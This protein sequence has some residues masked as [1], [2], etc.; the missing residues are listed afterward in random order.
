MVPKQAEMD[1]VV[2]QI[3]KAIEH[4]PHLQNTLFVLAGDHGMTQTG[5]HG[6]DTPSEIASAMV[7]IS[8]RFRSIS[9]GNEST[10]EA[11]EDFEYYSV[12][13]Q[14]DI[15]PTLAGL[16]GFS[17]PA[18]SV[19]LFVSELLALFEDEQDRL[20]VLLKNARQMMRLFEARY[21]VTTMDTASCGNQCNECHNDDS[22]VVCLWKKMNDVEKQWR[23][24]QDGA[25]EELTSAIHTVGSRQKLSILVIGA[26]VILSTMF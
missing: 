10:L 20:N 7:F 19:G 14:I 1:N 23:S 2:R 8:P 3:Y 25:N 17:V 6:G 18:N 21:D 9:G 4:Q 12:I 5:N 22:Q 16:L 24:A 13:N 26:L 11:S 15:V